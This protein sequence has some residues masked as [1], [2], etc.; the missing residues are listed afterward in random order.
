M[1][2]YFVNYLSRQIPRSQM[3]L[4]G[5]DRIHETG[6]NVIFIDRRPH[7]HIHIL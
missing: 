4:K 6:E 3:Y 7:I 1:I 2:N 5:T